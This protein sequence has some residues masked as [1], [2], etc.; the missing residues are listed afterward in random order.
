[1]GRKTYQRLDELAPLINAFGDEHGYRRLFGGDGAAV[2]RRPQHITEPDPDRIRR[3]LE[4]LGL[5]DQVLTVDPK[6]LSDLIESRRL[7]PAV[8]DALLASRQEVRTQHALYLR[9]ATPSRR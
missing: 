5:W 4:P 7:P 2:D 3:I 9:E 6:K 1:L 8:E